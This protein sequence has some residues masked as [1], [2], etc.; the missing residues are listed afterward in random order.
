MSLTA[1]DRLEILELV[2]LADNCAT[3]CDADGYA[4][5]FTE[6]ATMT[7]GMGTATGRDVL[8]QSVAAV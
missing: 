1:D 2:T 7:G 8:R 6:D 4:A 3:A 5:L